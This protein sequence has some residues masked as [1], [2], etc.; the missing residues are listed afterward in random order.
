MDELLAALRN[1]ASLCGLEREAWHEVLRKS[2]AHGLDAR[3]GRITEALGLLDRLPLGAQGQLRDSIAACELNQTTLSYEIERLEPALKAIKGP[4]ILLKGG[5]YLA[6]G[7]PPSRGRFSSD[8]DILV[9]RDQLGEVERALEQEGWQPGNTNEYD[10]N[11]YRS[12]MHELPPLWHPVRRTTIDVHHNLLPRTSRVSPCPETLIAN[13]RGLPGRTVKVLAPEDMV[14]HCAVHLVYSGELAA[15]LRDLV[16]LDDLVGHF[17]QAPE[18]WHRLATRARNHGLELAIFYVLRTA[19][20]LLHTRV[21]ASFWPD[22]G[23]SSARP[24]STRIVRALLIRAITPAPQD[25]GQ[26]GHR[27]AQEILYLRSHWL[28]MPPRLLFRHL[29]VKATK[30]ARESL[31]GAVEAAVPKAQTRSR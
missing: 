9:P 19:A 6:A 22:L 23:R 5:A 26:L 10:Q 1:P 20:D 29:S 14:L 13:S 25:V 4:V 8:L 11:Y 31:F 12:W 27:V 30:R 3:L 15:S 7:L 16:D 18:F 17:G 21:P 2:R 28:R 24:F